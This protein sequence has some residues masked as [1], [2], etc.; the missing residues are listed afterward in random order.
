VRQ[1]ASI[2]IISNIEAHPN[3]D[4]LEIA[5]ILG[6]KVCV[7]KG[8]YQI[9][10]KTVYIEADAMVPRSN[11]AFANLFKGL[12]PDA[13]FAKIRT[14][15]IR[16]FVSYGICYKIGQVFSESASSILELAPIGMDVSS[17]LGI[18]KYEMPENLSDPYIA[19]D[20]P[21][22]MCPKSDETRVQVLQELL[23]KYQGIPFAGTIK[24]DGE[25]TSLGKVELTT[26]IKSFKMACRERLLYTEEEFREVHPDKDN[27]MTSF[28]RAL[29]SVD[30]F[31]R[32]NNWCLLNGRR[33]T[34]QGETIGPGIQKNKYGLKDYTIRFFNVYDIDA[35]RYL[36]YVEKKRIL[37]EMGLPMVPV[38][39]EGFMLPATVGELLSMLTSD[40]PYETV[41]GRDAETLPKAM[42]EGVVFTPMDEEFQE[43][44]IEGR[45]L[46]YGRVSFK[47]INPCFSVKYGD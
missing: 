40:K 42:D 44:G 47:V 12:E 43:F 25:S 20:F 29:R 9:G 31:S 15:R 17:S 37:G 35:C 4:R 34:L 2:Q 21:S 11:S 45:L 16:G 3:A 26:G 18:V 39:V 33:L 8:E 27:E 32:L 5:T 41:S 14:A 24:L 46:H 36:P 13:E 1:L 6:W 7:G 19:A 30:A 38:F 10:D 22:W 28:E 23:V